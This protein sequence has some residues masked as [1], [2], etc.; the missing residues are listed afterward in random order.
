MGLWNFIKSQ[1]IEVIEWLDSSA[2]TLVWRFPDSDH[3]IKNGAKLIV[4]EGQV[5]VFV[6]EGEVA[7]VFQAGLHQ[8]TTQ[9]MPV[10]TKLKHWSHGFD[11]PFK[12]EVYF[13]NTKQY[14]DMKWGTQTPIM[15]RDKD[16]GVVRLRAFGNYSVQVSD[17]T[18]FM[19]EVVG[20]D[21]HFTTGEI[22]GALRAQVLSAFTEMLGKAQIPA[23]DLAANYGSIS[24]T[25]LV[26]IA[27]AFEAF[28]LTLRSFLI[29]N[30][31]LPPKLQEALDKRASM[32]ILGDVSTYQQF[33]AADAMMEAAKNPGGGAGAGMGLGAGIAMGQQMMNSMQAPQ[34]SAAAP[35]ATSPCVKCA[36]A[37]PAQAKFCNSCGAEQTQVDSAPC[38]QC[39][40]PIAVGASFCSHCGSKQVSTCPAC[41]TAAPA[42]AKFCAG[43]GEALPG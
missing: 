10:L 24:K 37:I 31:S 2:D 16:F 36:T 20:T 12:A 26:E 4:R 29:E 22:Q 35:A 41:N 18:K 5:A 32:G 38:V 40:E 1:V 25:A 27:P 19:R 43:C 23:L 33:Q 30:I 11:S 14:P 3:E 13:I 28:G 7:D 15:M 21:G 17:A 6:N 8:L 34:Q 39:K 42:G 9:N